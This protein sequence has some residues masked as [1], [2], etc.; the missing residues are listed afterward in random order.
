MGKFNRFWLLLLAILVIA[1]IQLISREV[2]TQWN[3]S[4][5]QQQTQQR[6]LDYIGDARRSLLRFYHLPY[7]VTNDARSLQY[8]QGDQALQTEIEKQLAKLD[9]ASNTQGWYILSAS[10]DILAA[11][12]KRYT[13]NELDIES[14]VA[15]IHKQKE[16][17]TIV[18]K[19]KGAMA[20]YFL[21]A[22][23]YLGFDISGIV[24]V[25]VD[26]SM[27]TE[28]WLTS[29]EIILVK[30]ANN[31]YFLSSSKQFNADWFNDTFDS[32][33]MSTPKTLFDDTRF[34]IWHLDNRRY[35]SHSVVLDDL[36][37]QLTYLS[38]ISTMEKNV[39]WLSWSMVVGCVLVCLLLIIRYQR[40]QKHLSQQR[41][42]KLLVE[43]EQRLNAMINKTHVGILL[44]DKHGM[45][46]DI[47]STA[48]RYFNLADSMIGSVEAWQLFDT[49][50]PYSTTL[51]LLK[52]LSQ[53]RELAELAS[54]ETFA[55]RSDGSHFPV[56]FSISQFPWHSHSYYLCT[57][58]DI[59]KRKKAEIALESANQLLQQRVE[60]RTKALEEAQQELIET[61]K[62]AALGRMSSAITHELNQ[63]L[64]GLR[65]LLSSNQLLIERGET[66]LA[67]ANLDLVNTLIDRMANMTSQLKSFAFKRLDRPQPVSLVLALEEVLRIE[68]QAL[69][70]IDVRVRI[71]QDIN[72]V[73]GEEVRLRQVL[74]NLIRNAIDATKDVAAAKI[75]INVQ[76]CNKQ[77]LLE[78]IDNGCGIDTEQ[79]DSIFEPFQ[80]SKKIGEGL[81]LGLAITAN[82]VKDMQGS[83][84]ATINPDS[85][86]TF[87]LFLKNAC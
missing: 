72:M 78:I 16:G 50:N 63:P 52:D 17:V 54:V 10:G 62:L 59:S 43:S 3:L 27:L 58:M 34:F 49:G 6:L 48:K 47:N 25:Q 5:I 32:A 15:Q 22:P 39:A 66:K 13:M 84:K 77:I 26:L 14:I 74:G 42:Q 40:H 29:D 46:T 68:Q 67:Q 11:S 1:S 12:S 24:V 73:L 61:S 7:L 57:V 86:M 69:E 21:A 20:E 71:G 23:M 60:E 35:L 51:R 64:T 65:T 56:L 18:T 41:I 79:L 81:G 2:A 4:A 45:I 8:L 28:Q 70:T 37:W 9:K 53:H 83:I 75:A 19:N 80:T 82:N 31:H 36:Q 87:S 85:G 33:E 30:N 38:P 44:L 76:H 55:R